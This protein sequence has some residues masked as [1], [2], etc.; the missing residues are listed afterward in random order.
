MPYLLATANL[1]C[2]SLS[3]RNLNSWMS[4]VFCA[5]CDVSSFFFVL[6]LRDYVCIAEMIC[7]CFGDVNANEF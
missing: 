1:N 6:N 4:N 5:F 2:S 3:L 7:A